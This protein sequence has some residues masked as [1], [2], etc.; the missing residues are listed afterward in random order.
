MFTVIVFLLILS[1][2]VFVHEFGHFIVARKSGMRVHEFG[3]GFPPRAIGI[4]RDPV[5]KKFIRVNSGNRSTLDAGTGTEL[6]ENFP[7]TVYSLNWLPIGGFCKIKGENGDDSR[8][9]DSFGYQ[10]AWKRLS[11]LVAGV[12]MNVLLAA[13]LFAIGFSIGLPTDATGGF[14]KDAI[15]V[16]PSRVAVVDVVKGSPAYL[17]GVKFGDQIIFVDENK[18]TTAKDFSS[19]TASHANRP[20]TLTILRSGKQITLDPAQPTILPNTDGVP[21]LGLQLADAAIIRYPWYLAIPKGFVAAWIGLVNIYVTFYLLIKNILL[22]HGLI[23]AVSG[24]VG[25]AN[26]VGESARMGL[27]YLIQVTASISL[28]LAAINILPI[29]ALDGGR[30]LFVVIEKIFRRR[31]PI[32]YEQIAHAIGFVLL[33]VLI[34]IVTGKDILGLVR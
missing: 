21:H 26:V 31:V 13:V 22:G 18:V 9:T 14:D 27:N 20:V 8:D 3:L 28:S 33:L 7:A 32:K 16:E 34:V 15:V 19:Y 25:I 1:L 24:P 12:L 23:F 5:T 30:A 11:V 10:K 2:L 29:P 4:Y 17:A 6:E